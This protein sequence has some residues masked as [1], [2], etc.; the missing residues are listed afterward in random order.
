MGRPPGRR[1]AA[2]LFAIFEGW[3]YADDFDPQ[4]AIFRAEAREFISGGLRGAEAPLFH[5]VFDC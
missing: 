3:K 1:L 5:F 4:K 2:L